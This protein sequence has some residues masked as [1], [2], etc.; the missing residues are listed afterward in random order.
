MIGFGVGFSWAGVAI[1]LGP[2]DYLEIGL[3]MN[4]FNEKLMLNKTV[5][6]TGASS[7]LG[8]DLAKRLSFL[9]ARV[10]CLG[11]NIERLN[12]TIKE[13]KNQIIFLIYPIFQIWNLLIRPLWFVEKKLTKLM[14][15]FMQLVK[16]L[17]NLQN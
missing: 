5:V 10:I 1:N 16:S 8:K 3:Y 11:R 13:L 6:V 12:S 2:I 14:E 17:Q 9:G 15:F 4:I 7:G